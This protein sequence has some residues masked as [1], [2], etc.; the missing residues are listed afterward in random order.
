MD[1]MIVLTASTY[2]TLMIV[3]IIKFHGRETFRDENKKWYK[4]LIIL[5]P[6]LGIS[7]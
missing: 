7:T 2:S 3:L 6:Y 1:A 4:H 5:F